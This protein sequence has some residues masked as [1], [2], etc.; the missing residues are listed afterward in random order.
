[1]LDQ[2]HGVDFYC[3]HGKVDFY[4]MC[5]ADGSCVRCLTMWLQPKKVHKSKSIFSLYE[6]CTDIVSL[7]GN[8]V[9]VEGFEELTV[10]I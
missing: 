10:R 3:Q 2:I 9:V 4:K 1:M 5:P 7:S 6:I 8:Y